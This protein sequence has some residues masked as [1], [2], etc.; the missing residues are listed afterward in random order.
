MST[1]ANAPS[2]VVDLSE[3]RAQRAARVR[4]ASRVRR[5]FLWSWP[6][7]QIVAAEFPLPAA[8]S[9]HRDFARR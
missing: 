3:V 2:K 9:F 8:D 1:P 7:G 6:S 4:S 5:P